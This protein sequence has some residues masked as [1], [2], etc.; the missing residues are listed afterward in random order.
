M[1]HVSTGGHF[2]KTMRPVP[3]YK[4]TL[5]CPSSAKAVHLDTQAPNGHARGVPNPLVGD[6]EQALTFPSWHWLTFPIWHWLT[7]PSW[8]WLMF[9]SWYWLMFL[10]WH[11][12]MFVRWPSVRF[13]AGTS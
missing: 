9:I 12:L 8:H 3:P 5:K 4:L 13:S 10:S 7:F 11:W 2:G 6:F 1:P